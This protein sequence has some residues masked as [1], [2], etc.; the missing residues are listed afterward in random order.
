MHPID[1]NAPAISLLSH[2]FLTDRDL[3]SSTLILFR[4]AFSCAED[5][6]TKVDWSGEQRMVH[7]RLTKLFKHAGQP[8]INAKDCAIYIATPSP[9][10]FLDIDDLLPTDKYHPAPLHCNRRDALL[11]YRSRG[12]DST[13]QISPPVMRLCA[14]QVCSW[15]T[16]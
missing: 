16:V 7:Q 14:R 12:T 1:K 9:S 13:G 4:S 11:L 2:L 3:T 8:P 6:L 15:H 10:S 5:T